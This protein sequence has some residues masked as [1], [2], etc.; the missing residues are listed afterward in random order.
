VT[1]LRNPV[2]KSYRRMAA[3]MERFEKR[4]HLAPGATLRFKL[5]PRNRQTRLE[6][7]ELQVVGDSFAEPLEVAPDRTFRLPRDAKALQENASVRPN[8]RAGTLT[9]RAEVRTP[10]LPPGTRRLGDLRLECEVGMEARLISNYRRDLVGRLKELFPEGPDYCQREWPRYLF[11]A[12][13][14]LWSVTLVSGARRQA[15]SVD[16]LYGG[17]SRDP[18]WKE[19]LPYCDCEVLIDRA[20]F[21][22]L[23]DPSWPDDTRV[24]FEYL[25]D[26]ASPAGDALGP[27]RSTKADVRAALGEATVVDFPSG[28]EVWVYREPPAAELVL[29]FAPSGVLARARN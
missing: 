13:R 26:P 12:E 4:R 15:L 25:E 14:P 16:R 29:L 22:P 9:W 7:I 27:G 2:D 24:K 10:G 11:F 8:R 5:L 18:E 19:D 28:Y 1:A 21:L 6:D 3:G 23:G 17:A 20:Y